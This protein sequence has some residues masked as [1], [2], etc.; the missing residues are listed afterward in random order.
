VFVYGF[1][2]SIRNLFFDKGIF[3]QKKVDAKVI[4]IGNLTV[5]GSGKTP[6]V[7]YVTNLL[8][9]KFNVGVIS[10]GY[11]RTTSGYLQVSSKDKILV[12]VQES[13]DE[14]YLIADECKVTS[15]VSE[16]RVEG[17]KRLLTSEDLDV[18]VLDDAFQHRWI[19]RDLDI[20][21]FDQRFLHKIGSQEQKLLPLGIMRESFSSI[22]RA[23]IVIINSKFSDKLEIPEKLKKHFEGKKIFFANYKNDGIYDLKTHK[24]YTLEEFKG[25]KSLVVCGIARPFSFLNILEKS[26]INIDNKMIFADHKDYNEKEIQQ[27]RKKF[28][29]TNSFDVLTTQ[30]DAV[31]LT[32]FSKDMDDIDIFYLKIDLVIEKHEEFNQLILN[33][34]ANKTNN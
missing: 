24:H 32:H 2:T 28:Y 18:L 9:E 30:K 17:A 19:S 13:G 14:M 20:L 33:K 3:H 11:G 23:D 34:L 6:L 4:S 27:I 12:D 31:K 10:R 7:I 26:G 29:D 1:V 5:G 15:A 21:I 22:K 16:K 8:K 25:Q